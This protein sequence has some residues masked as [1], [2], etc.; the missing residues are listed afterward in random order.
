[1]VL[2][3]AGLPSVVAGLLLPIFALA[4]A[5]AQRPPEPRPV[6]VPGHWKL[7]RDWGAPQMVRW[8]HTLFGDQCTT[9]GKITTTRYNKL[10]LTTSGVVDNCAEIASPRIIVPGEVIQTRIRW[11]VT[12]AGSILN[13]PAFWITT[14]TWRIWPVD[15]EIDVAEDWPGVGVCTSYHYSATGIPGF[16]GE[17]SSQSFCKPLPIRPGWHVYS[18]EW[19]AKSLRYYYDGKLIGTVT[20]SFIADK[21]LSVVYD[22]TTGWPGG[23]GPSTV[24][25]SSTLV[26]RK[27]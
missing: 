8:R 22:N 21:P 7:I 10:A 6:G 11:P 12:S 16:A 24:L 20:G 26:W 4:P 14:P 19:L 25:V 3:K 2:R 18:V 5:Q 1:M 27:A 17:A 9:A 15:G 23:Q 13:W